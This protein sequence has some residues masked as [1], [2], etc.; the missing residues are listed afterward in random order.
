MK[1]L[2]I[3]LVIYTCLLSILGYVMFTSEQ[4]LIANMTVFVTLNLVSAVAG[5]LL[6]VANALR[7][8][9]ST[10]LEEKNGKL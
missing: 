1:N 3:H 5:F 10:L 7:T 8:I 6:G 9:K 4:G 2:E